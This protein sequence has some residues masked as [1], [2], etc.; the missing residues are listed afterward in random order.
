MRLINDFK[1]AAFHFLG[2]DVVFEKTKSGY[3]F[4]IA[5]AGRLTIDFDDLCNLDEESFISIIK[6]QRNRIGPS[7]RPLPRKLYELV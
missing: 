1:K 4:G 7:A 3:R 5:N 6:A 2:E